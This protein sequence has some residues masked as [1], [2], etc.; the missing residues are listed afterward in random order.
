MTSFAPQTWI[1][2]L[3]VSSYFGETEGRPN[4]HRGVDITTP[5]ACTAP[6]TGTIT[7]GV[8]DGDF[9]RGLGLVLEMVSDDGRF[10]FRVGHNNTN[11]DMGF[12]AG[13][14]IDRGQPVLADLGR[15]TTGQSSG[16]HYHEEL[17]DNGRMVNLLD[18]LGRVWGS[19]AEPEASGWDGVSTLYQGNY[20][21]DGMV[22]TIR[23]GETI[24]DVATARGLSLDQV[25]AWTA[26]LAASPYAAGQLAKSGGGASWWDGSDTYYAG[27]TIAVADVAGSFAAEDARVA[28]ARQVAAEEAETAAAEALKAIDIAA[29]ALDAAADHEKAAKVQAANEQTAREWAATDARIQAAAAAKVEAE[30]RLAASIEIARAALPTIVA[31]ID[32][33]QPV[34]V[35]NDTPQPALAGL[36]AQHPTARTTLYVAYAITALVLSFGADVITWGLITDT[37]MP[38]FTKW[39]G[40]ASSVVLKIGTAFGFVAAANITRKR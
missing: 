10:V 19:H 25:R 2:P 9:G 4:P 18:Y 13:D 21:D 34:E 20:A 38:E 7:R 12:R 14:R 29:V 11:S 16:P 39:L 32:A 22:Y 28:A 40:F 6:F 26:A 35:V 3:Q 31:T 8:G 37:A 23:V 30:E 33:A 17:T 27:C 5:G 1:G 36:L 15:P 24:W